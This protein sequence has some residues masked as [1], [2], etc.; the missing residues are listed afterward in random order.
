MNSKLRAYT[1]DI[2]LASFHLNSGAASSVQGKY[3]EMLFL[4]R[5]CRL[6]CKDIATIISH[7][8]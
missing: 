4:L 7:A 8:N 6:L 3:H 5:D 2:K 1:L